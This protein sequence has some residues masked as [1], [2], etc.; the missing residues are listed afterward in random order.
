VG[1]PDDELRADIFGLVVDLRR[2]KHAN[3]SASDVTDRVLA[4]FA[5]W[6]RRTAPPAL[7]VVERVVR[8][9][10]VPEDEGAA[11][12]A[13]PPNHPEIPD[14]SRAAVPGEPRACVC[15]IPHR[16]ACPN[17]GFDCEMCRRAP[18]PEAHASPADPTGA[19]PGTCERCGGR[20]EVV[21]SYSRTA[22]N[23]YGDMIPCPSCAGAEPGTGKPGGER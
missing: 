14:S 18:R 6:K 11:H 15:P 4:A 5:K 10:I 13:V 17:C 23:P 8:H 22:A 2:G 9:P 12:P 3:E 20:R 7:P 21:K 16:N 19:E 1:K